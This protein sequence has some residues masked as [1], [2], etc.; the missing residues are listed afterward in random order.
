MGNYCLGAR[1]CFTYVIP[2]QFFICLN[3]TNLFFFF[4]FAVRLVC[5]FFKNAE[6]PQTCT[7]HT[8]PFCPS[9]VL[10]LIARGKDVRICFSWAIQYFRSAV[11]LINNLKIKSIYSLIFITVGFAC[12]PSAPAF[13]AWVGKRGKTKRTALVSSR[14][15][16]FKNEMELQGLAVRWYFLL[17]HFLA[18]SWLSKQKRF[19]RFPVCSAKYEVIYMLQHY[20]PPFYLTATWKIKLQN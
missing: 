4:F 2:L 7:V 17:F 3:I 15:R 14:L 16:H 20:W 19:W 10:G 1:R 5:L 18:Y 9:S 6:L 11:K 13:P 8:L 12:K